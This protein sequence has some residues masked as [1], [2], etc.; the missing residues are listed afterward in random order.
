MSIED[1]MTID[2]RRKYIRKMQ[3]RYLQ[4]N[5]KER[6]QLLDDV[7]E[8]AERGPYPLNHADAYNVLAQIERD[9]GHTEAAVEAATGAHR[10]AW[11]DGPPFAYHW[12][13]ETARAHL[14]ALGAPQP[15]DLL[16]YRESRYEPM[17]DVEINPPDE[18][19]V[20]E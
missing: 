13:L 8:P 14:V 3:E 4:A 11:C 19:H 7:W 17:P 12:G 9:A 15:T 20:E 16:P 1:K 5:H 6:G 2:E 10:R 18:F